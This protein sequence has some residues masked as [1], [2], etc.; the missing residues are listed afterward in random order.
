[1]CPLFTWYFIQYSYVQNLLYKVVI[2]YIA[3]T[4]SQDKGTV[5]FASCGDIHG[6]DLYTTSI[7]VE[8]EHGII[9]IYMTYCMHMVECNPL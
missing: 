2:V 5:W 6:K 1:M 3:S 4:Y 8:D 9:Y 7:T